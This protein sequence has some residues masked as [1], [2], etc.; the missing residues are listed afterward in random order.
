MGGSTL[1][2]HWPRSPNVFMGAAVQNRRRDSKVLQVGFFIDPSLKREKGGGVIISITRLTKRNKLTQRKK[3]VFLNFS[4]SV[5]FFLV[6]VTYVVAVDIFRRSP[7]PWTR[8]GPG[9]ARCASS[10][11]PV[12]RASDIPQA[13]PVSPRASSQ[14][15]SCASWPQVS[16]RRRHRTPWRT[17][18][19]PR[20][21]PWL[22]APQRSSSS[23]PPGSGRWRC[24]ATERD[25]GY[26]RCSNLYTNTISYVALIPISLHSINCSNNIVVT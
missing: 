11:S 26:L 7:W 15:P 18:W 16:W 8:W 17:W 23:W 2:P 14:A 22:W 5:L 12:E 1:A 4:L 10:A 24:P 21:W 25:R 3:G 9:R 6:S 19:T 13:S 20:S